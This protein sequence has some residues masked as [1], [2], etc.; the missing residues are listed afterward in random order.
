[1]PQVGVLGYVRGLARAVMSEGPDQPVHVTPGGEVVIAQGLPPE[2]ELTRQG[3]GWAVIG[4]AVANVVAIPTTGAHLSLYNASQTRS[5]IISAVGTVVTATNA[6]VGQITLLAR[7][8]VPAFNANPGG[9]LIITGTTGKAYTGLTNAKASVT[10]GAIGAGNNV[11]WVPVASS[12]II[13]ATGIGG[14]VHAE[15]Y[16]RWIVQ[17]LGLFSLATLAY[18]ASGSSQPYVYFYEALLPLP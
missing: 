1:M 3:A 6:A 17:P 15:V 13:Q 8:D 10:L 11:A 2:A 12:A 14:C 4:S 16:G 9:A 18:A 7:N 5:L